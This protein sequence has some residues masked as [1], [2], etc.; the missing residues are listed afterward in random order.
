[1]NKRKNKTFPICSFAALCGLF[2]FVNHVNVAAMPSAGEKS[3][4]LAV[5][6]ISVALDQYY[7]LLE[8]GQIPLGVT[9]GLAV[10]TGLTKEETGYVSVLDVYSNLGIA[11]VDGYL[12]I[13]KEPDQDGEIVGTLTAN[14]GCE[15][16]SKEDGWYQ[17]QS[18]SVTGFVS[19]EFLATGSEAEDLAKEA[20]SLVVRVDTETLRIRTEPSTEA[21]IWDQGY[22]GE[23]YDVI[24]DLGNGWVEVLLEGDDADA[25]GSNGYVYTPGNATLMYTLTEAVEHSSLETAATGFSKIRKNAV[26][27][28]MQFLGNPYVW[29]GTDPNTGADCSGFV[30]YVLKNTAGVTLNRTSRDQVRHG[31]EVEASNMKPGDL[32]FYENNKG[33]I[34]HV[35]MY[36]GNEQVIHSASKKTGVKISRWNYRKPVAIRNI[37]G[38]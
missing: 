25:G 28:A 8:K 26:D 33:T 7:Q 36:I 11:R 30:Q 9:Q 38:S 20:A 14:G 2:V 3:P 12:N 5:A 15:V 10:I 31:T 6:G 1:M 21:R 19:A 16:L 13:R 37:I 22:G 29:G 23:S 4:G 24:N 17:I 32:V 34:N 35:A 27:Y 18:G